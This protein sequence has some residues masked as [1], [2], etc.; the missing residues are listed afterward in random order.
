MVAMTGM[1]HDLASLAKELESMQRK[2]ERLRESGG[3]KSSSKASSAISSVDDLTKQ[4]ESKA[5]YIFEKLQLVDENRINHL[6]AVLTQFETH[7]ADQVER[8]RQR[9]ESCLNALLNV[10]TADEIKTF[11]VKLA[12]GQ[13]FV[14]P[15]RRT[16]SFTTGSNPTAAAATAA[17]LEPLPPPP[18]IQDDAASQRSE[19]SNRARTGATSPGIML[20]WNY[21]YRRLT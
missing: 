13:I 8:N 9:A 1:S 15:R 21:K 5:P 17:A 12:G 7:E 11:A 20:F 3:R 18:R 16:A 14:Q 6:S 4:W 10:E 2:I 19:G